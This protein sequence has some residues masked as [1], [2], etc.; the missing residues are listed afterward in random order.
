MDAKTRGIEGLP[1]VIDRK[2]GDRG[3]AGREELERLRREI[4]PPAI[5]TEA[6]P[7]AEYAYADFFKAKVGN[8]NTR[9]AYKRAVDRFLF[10][11]RECGVKLHEVT[12]F[13][14]GD[15]LEHALTD[16]DGHQLAPPSKKQHLAALRHFFDNQQMYHSIL[17]NPALSVRGPK[18]SAHEGKTPAFGDRQVK[19]LLKSID[20]GDIV[21]LRDKTLLMVLAYTAAR[22]GAIAKLRMVDY[23][24]DGTQWWFNFGEKGGKLHLVPARHDLQLQM[25]SYIDDARLRGQPDK[26][27]LFRTAR[28]KRKREPRQLSDQGLSGN[29]LLRIVKRRLKAAG[30]PANTFCCHSFRAT[31]A[32]DLLK[33]KVPREEVQYLLGH[34]DARTTDLYDRTKKEVTRNIVERISI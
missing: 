21:G 18:Y 6:G 2:R 22:A 26:S 7:N 4:Q 15:Y 3:L 17:I 30:L 25:A 11:C 31:A 10:W 29:D 5:V 27:P 20:V 24:S 1:E 14:I 28:K 16:K 33:Q 13:L 8:V 9:K 34:S 23:Y 19:A 32:T 12:S